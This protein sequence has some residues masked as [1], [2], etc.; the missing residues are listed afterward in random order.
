MNLK[1]KSWA[2]C[3]IATYRRLVAVA[4]D[5][6]SEAEKDIAAI[7]ILCK[8]SEDEVWKL[9]VPEV[10]TLISQLNWLKSFDFDRNPKMN[11]LSING[12][13]CNV[14]TDLTKFT[15][16]QYIDFQ[17]SY[18]KGITTDNLPVLLGT[19]LIPEGKNYNEGYDLQEWISDIDNYLPITMANSIGFFLLQNLERQRR[20]TQL[21]LLW[22]Q[23]RIVKR[24]KRRMK[25]LKRKQK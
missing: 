18:G 1:I 24:E 15:V 22:M 12:V 23:K 21:Y 19:I 9:T 2:E 3:P 16:A 8:E 13:K 7:A 5:N 25:R 20:I 10:Q 6:L 17:S 4:E 11:K 14:D